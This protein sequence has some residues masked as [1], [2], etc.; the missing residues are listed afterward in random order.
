MKASL[1]HLPRMSTIVNKLY[2]GVG[3]MVKT[4][5]DEKPLFTSI[6]PI[7][8]PNDNSLN[9]INKFPKHFVCFPI[10][11][12]CLDK[13]LQSKHLYPDE[14]SHRE[15]FDENI[16]GKNN[17]V[18][19]QTYSVPVRAF[20]DQPVNK[21]WIGN[22]VINEENGIAD[23]DKMR[24]NYN[25]W[26]EQMNANVDDLIRTGGQGR[27]ETTYLIVEDNEAGSEFNIHEKVEE[28]MQHLVTTLL[29]SIHC[30]DITDRLKIICLLA[31]ALKFKLENYWK[32]LMLHRAHVDLF[33][34][35]W[36][37]WNDMTSFTA[38]FWNGRYISS[39]PFVP[40]MQKQLCRPILV[41]SIN[42]CEE[43]RNT[44]I[45][46]SYA[47]FLESLEINILT[48]INIPKHIVGIKPF[49][50]QL[51][52]HDGKLNQNLL[53]CPCCRFMFLQHKTLAFFLFFV[54]FLEKYKK[55]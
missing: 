7:K 18:R 9:E 50:K 23:M 52:K 39:R 27:M 13:E 25:Q 36:D 28:S 30:F 49:I 55:S 40:D 38:T 14:D 8:F 33:G 20:A 51:K 54:V 21:S 24:E 10:L 17:I 1:I 47:Q 42:Q 3:C 11:G 46:T 44:L 15:C 34:D 22:Y 6:N 35:F 45:K 48:L 53:A 4:S 43:T 26:L 2:V 37:V 5:I 31:E 29:T 16:F 12:C 41:P 19:C 32:T